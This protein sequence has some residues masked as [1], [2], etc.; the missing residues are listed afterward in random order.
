MWIVNETNHD[1]QMARGD[2][3]IDLPFI[4][5]ET[6]LTSH[7]SIKFT[8]KKLKSNEVLLEKE[9]TGEDIQSNTVNLNFTEEDTKKFPVGLYAY[10][11][12]WYQNG[13]FMC[14]LI[15]AATLKVVDKT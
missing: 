9:Y 11:V 13:S 12:D 4:V 2:F 3:G 6:E 7:D 15:E 10:G 14:N 8:F 5:E 1:L